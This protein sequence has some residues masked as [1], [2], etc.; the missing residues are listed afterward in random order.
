MTD[1]ESHMVLRPVFS[2]LKFLVQRATSQYP[3]HRRDCRPRVRNAPF[4]HVPLAE[5][6]RRRVV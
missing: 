4:P 2:R 6:L 5:R 3:A 1:S